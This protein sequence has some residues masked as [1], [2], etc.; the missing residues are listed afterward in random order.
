M[1]DKNTVKSAR[2]QLKFVNDSDNFPSLSGT[3]DLALAQHSTKITMST[4]YTYLY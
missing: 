4:D 2:H 3:C 1:L